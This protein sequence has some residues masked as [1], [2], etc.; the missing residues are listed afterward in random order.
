MGAHLEIT[1]DGALVQSVRAGGQ[2]SLALMITHLVQ[3]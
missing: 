3:A 1:Q 2:L